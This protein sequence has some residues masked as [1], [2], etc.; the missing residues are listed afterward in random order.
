MR[1]VLGARH[2]VDGQVAP[3][4]VVFQRD[5]GRG[6]EHEA[7]VAGRGLALG[8][9]QRVFLLR[10]RD[11]GRPGNPCRPGGSPAPASR[12]AWRRPRQSWSL[13]R[14]PQQFIA[15]GAADDI[16]LHVLT[17]FNPASRRRAWAAVS[18]SASAS[19]DPARHG[20]MGQHA[21]AI[22]LQRRRQR[23]AVGA[24]AHHDRRVEGV[25]DRKVA[26]Q[27]A[28]GGRSATGTL[29]RSRRCGR[30]RPGRPLVRPRPGKLAGCSSTS[31]CAGRRS[32]SASR[33]RPSAPSRAPPRPAA[34]GAFRGT[35][36][37]GIG[38]P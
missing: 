7:V 22:G 27:E 13:H 5:V 20:R 14:Q 10:L 32:R 3:D 31:R 17:V 36:R 8:A 30:C 2:R 26:E 38:G 15:H 18:V 6:V 9:R 1:A 21:V 25:G 33:R 16:N 23:H 29:P 28:G 4:Q 24:E 35:A 11:A 37:P 12:R 34:T 19:V